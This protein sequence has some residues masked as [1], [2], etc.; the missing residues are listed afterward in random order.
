MALQSSSFSMANAERA[1][2]VR[3]V[4][5][6]FGLRSGVAAFGVFTI[7][8]GLSQSFTVSL[9]ALVLLG[10]GPVFFYPIAKTVWAA[11]EMGLRRMRYEPL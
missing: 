7:V 4:P 5:L 2:Q 1:L 10:A 6:P 9:I 8:F 11:I 3:V